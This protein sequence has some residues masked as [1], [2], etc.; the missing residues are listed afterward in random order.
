MWDF[1]QIKSIIWRQSTE[2]F[3]AD[4]QKQYLKERHKKYVIKSYVIVIIN[5]AIDDIEMY[6]QQMKCMIIPETIFI[7]DTICNIE[8]LPLF[9]IFHHYF[10]TADSVKDQIWTKWN[11]IVAS[12]LLTPK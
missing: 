11:H 12:K 3:G 7:H 4:I 2:N 5:L 8:V 1:R 10:P 9:S 6:F